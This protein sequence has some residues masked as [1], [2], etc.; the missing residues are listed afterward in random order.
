M[1]TISN[2]KLSKEL[3]YHIN[4]GISLSECIFRYGSDKHLDIINEARDLH[5]SGKL[6]LEGRDKV[7][8]SL[9][10]GQKAMYKNKEV[11]LHLPQYDDGANKKFLV[12]L[13]TDKKHENGL[14]IAK[15]QR[16]GDPNATIKN[17]DKKAADS[18]QARHNCDSKLDINSAGFWSCNIHIFADHLGLS[19]SRPW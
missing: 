18:F 8:A 3:E 16:F 15:I 10:T 11:K 13:E 17:H 12:Y 19:S 4:N 5:N 14:P 6:I 9:K 2:I 1:K 7:I